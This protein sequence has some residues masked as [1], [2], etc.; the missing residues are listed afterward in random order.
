MLYSVSGAIFG[1]ALDY[2]G[3]LEAPSIKMR[4]RPASVRLRLISAAPIVPGG[5]QL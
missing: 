3:T 1:Y 2:H 4:H 5:H